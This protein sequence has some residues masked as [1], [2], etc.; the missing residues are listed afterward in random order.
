MAG[1]VW[2]LA[3]LSHGELLGQGLRASFASQAGSVPSV[4]LPYEAPDPSEP[5]PHDKL[6]ALWF[7]WGQP[8]PGGLLMPGFSLHLEVPTPSHPAWFY[9]NQSAS[10]LLRSVRM[11]C[12]EVRISAA[13]VRLAHWSRVLRVIHRSVSY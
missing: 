7:P 5:S 6:H 12:S 8:V 1:F 11:H 10:S 4:L 13:G 3:A 9:A 2:V